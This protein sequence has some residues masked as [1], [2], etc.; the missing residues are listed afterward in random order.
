MSGIELTLSTILGLTVL[1]ALPILTSLN[2]DIKALKDFLKEKFKEEENRVNGR[3]QHIKA[4][5]DIQIN[6]T[7]RK[8]ELFILKD[9][10]IKVGSYVSVEFIPRTP[11]G[12]HQ[13]NIEVIK[14]KGFVTSIQLSDDLSPIYQ[15]STPE[16]HGTIYSENKI[17]LLKCKKD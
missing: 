13:L 6:R 17:K 2:S 14:T 8:V 7:M 4:D 11:Y 3:I 10:P 9:N 15:V 1:S 5:C 12:M 16:G